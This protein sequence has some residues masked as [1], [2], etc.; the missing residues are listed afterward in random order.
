MSN[1]NKT[2][3]I[4]ESPSKCGKIQKFLGNGYIVKA[5]VGHV[6]EIPRKGLNINIENGFEPTYVVSKDKKKVVDELKELASECKHVILATDPDREGEAISYSVFQLL[7]KSDQ[8][9]CSRVTFNEITEKAIKKA[10]ANPRDIDMDLVNSQKCRQVLDRLIG[11]KISP[12][13]WKKIQDKTSA[14]RVQSIA[15]KILSDREIE[16][17]NFKPEDFWQ[18]FA[19]LEPQKDKDRGSFLAKVVTTHKD[20]RFLDEDEA[21]EALE[22]LKK[23]KYGIEKVE[24]KKKNVNPYPPFDTS[25]LQSTAS[26]LW[27]WPVKKTAQIAQKLYEKG[28]VTYIRSDSFAIA[29]DALQA[30]RSF[31]AEEYSKEYLPKSSQKYEKK[32]N[33]SSQEAHECIRPTD[34]QNNG[35]ELSGDEEKL[36]CLIRDRFIACQMNPMILNTVSYLIKTNTPHKLTASGQSVAF[37]GWKKAYPY[38]KTKEEVLPDLQQKELLDLIEIKKSHHTTQPPPRYNE[39]S[40]VKKMESDGVG[41]PSTYPSIMESIQMRGYV[42][43]VKKGKSETLKPT[44]LGLSIYQFLD[45]SFNDFFMDIKFTAEMERKL[46]T[47]ASGEHTFLDTTSDFYALLQKYIAS[48]V[49]TDSSL[50][51]TG[52]PCLACQ[53]GEIVERNGKFGK[54]FSCN[55]YPQCKTTFRLEGDSFVIIEK[56]KSND[57]GIICPEC[58]KNNKKSTLIERSNKKDGSKFLGCSAYPSCRYTQSA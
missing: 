10:L 9:K 57:T 50:T 42:E 4:V 14:G 30:V 21:K 25:S 45:K 22:K 31:I 27:K 49:G 23:A 6:Q 55:R 58:A 44:E 5:S 1:S 36:Y 35:E 52:K 39:G 41:R 8:K 51:V 28:M 3:L 26:G 24:K 17:Q 15:L 34:V 53:E 2:L 12:I 33:A 46:D 32:S 13:L 37:Q 48:V 18:I 16:I 38:G 56:G 40:L 20:N 7:K 29:D 11:Y 54:F 19:N 47:I 43:T